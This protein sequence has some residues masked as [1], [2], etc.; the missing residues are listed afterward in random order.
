M[1]SDRQW[2]P[3]HEALGLSPGP[4][5]WEVLQ[6]AVER[7]LRET[8]DLDWKKTIY[9]SSD[10][11]W[12]YEASKDFAAM[13]NSDGGWIIFGVTDQ[14]DRADELI[15]VQWSTV[16]EQ[17]LRK[18]AV[19]RVLP[20]LTGL[21]FIEVSP[22]DGGNS[23]VCLRVPGHSGSLHAVMP[24]ENTFKVPYRNGPDTEF[25][26]PTETGLALLLLAPGTVI[27]PMA[28][29]TSEEMPLSPVE[30]LKSWL[31]LQDRSVAVHDLI[32]AEVATVV[33]AI[34]GHPI[35]L[36]PLDGETFEDRLT[37]YRD[38]VQPL[39][40][41]IVTGLWHDAAGTHDQVWVDALQK[42]VTA[43]S[44]QVLNRP[45]QD[46][47][48][49]A[50]LY[51]ALLVLFS[52][53]IAAVIRGRE[54]LFIRLCTEVT[55][56]RHDVQVRQPACQILH[57]WWVLDAGWVNSM[58]RWGGGRWTYP[59]SHLLKMDTRAFFQEL[60][61]DD[62]DFVEAFHGTEYRLGLLQQQTEEQGY[63]ALSGEYVG[64]RGWTF[65]RPSVPHAEIAF[66]AAGERS[67]DWP[68]AERLG[69]IEGYDSTLVNH[70]KV[71]ENYQYHRMH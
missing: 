19:R 31:G 10:P 2:S 69:G 14:D 46:V 9:H 7:R 11:K 51:P 38:T 23:V 36:K 24:D 26:G 54:E 34:E 67:R 53:G 68:W 66:R 15:G 62:D 35:V 12:Q 57:P 28:K 4:L 5:T 44:S 49:K 63:P 22:P 1:T 65:T 55:G 52:A 17:R 29:T 60:I 64:E 13:A 59:V 56:M 48:L 6:C 8:D 41:L 42:L 43:G 58:P 25:H 37:N 20:A 30:Q 50:R 45:F 71:L 21:E 70:R 27:G 16:E 39:I 18:V 32:M 61:P 3:I 40:D 47:L 33:E